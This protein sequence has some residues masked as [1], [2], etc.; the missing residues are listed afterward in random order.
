MVTLKE[1]YEDP[2]QPGAFSGVHQLYKEARRRGI[3]ITKPEVAYW[4]RKRLSYTLHKPARKR[5]KRNK[6]VVFYRDELWQMD[7]CDMKELKEYN[8]G[9]TFLLTVI[10]VFSKMGFAKPLTDKRGVTVLNGFKEILSESNR[11][12][13]KVQTDAG[14]EFTNKTFQKHLKTVGIKFYVTF[15][16]VK[17]AVVERFNRSL[18]TKMWRYFTH[19]NTYRYIDVLPELL[20]GYNSTP[21]SG[22]KGRTP[23]SVTDNNNLA[24][25]R[26]S[27]S[28]KRRCNPKFKFSVGDSVRIS[29]DKGIFEKGYVNS[30][31]EEYFLVD[32]ALPRNPP[33]YVLRDLNGEQLKGVFYEPQLQPI[34]PGEV[35][36]ISKIQRRRGKRGLVSW[37]G[38]PSPEFDSWIPL[39]DINRI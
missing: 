34:S 6:T 9:I 24:V 39:A 16:E 14:T 13:S 30:W 11:K 4:L 37:R 20:K 15:S 25:W 36:P 33:V 32:Q 38:W 12:P 31:S 17:A 22:I 23:I 7:L 1:I 28:T 18:K 35:Y 10:D 5:F 27:Y 19:K 2:S 21:H 29:R 26:E 3:K 8:D